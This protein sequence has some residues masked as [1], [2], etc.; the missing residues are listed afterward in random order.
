MLKSFSACV[1]LL[2]AGLITGFG[3]W[4]VY[5][6]ARYALLLCGVKFDSM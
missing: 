2:F 4:G 6:A 1:I 3:L 5:L